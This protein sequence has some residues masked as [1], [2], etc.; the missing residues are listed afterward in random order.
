M[1]NFDVHGVPEKNSKGLLWYSIAVTLLFV[2]FLTFGFIKID[3][4]L[5]HTQA[6]L[7][8]INQRYDDLVYENEILWTFVENLDTYKSLDD[9]V[10]WRDNQLPDLIQFVGE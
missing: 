1:Q 6:A 8:K 3:V 4:Q 7:E 9:A 10:N 2:A 5:I